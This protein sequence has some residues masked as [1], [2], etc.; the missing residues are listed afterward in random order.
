MA[1][2]A[3]LFRL[4][5][6]TG[7][8]LAGL[9]LGP[10]G[11]GI[12]TQDIVGHQLDHF[13]QI[14][15]MLIAFGIGEHVELRRLKSVARD[16]G[17]I[18]IIQ[19]VSAFLLVSVSVYAVA[20]RGESGGGLNLDHLVLALLLGAIAVA[21]AP[22]AILHLV[23]ELKAR[24]PLTSTLMAV[25]AVDD[26]IAIM[27]FGIAVSAAHQI[28][29]QTG[30][31]IFASIL[32]SSAE[33][34]LSLVMGWITGFTMDQ[35]MKK[36]H[37]G[38]ETL[39]GGL[40]ILLILGEATRMLHLSPLLAG[41]MAGFTLINRAERDVRLFRTINNFEPPIFVLFF[42]LAGVHLDISALKAGG[43]IGATYFT[44]RIIGKYGGA[45][46]GGLLS[47]ARPTVRNYLGL[48]LIPQA[49]VAIGLVFI[50]ASDPQLSPWATLITPIVLAGVVLSEL[51]GPLLARVALEKG[52]ETGQT[53]MGRTYPGQRYLF[54]LHRWLRPHH[55]FSLPPWSDTPLRPPTNP[56]GV[57][58]FSSNDY[59]PVR[60]LARIATILAHH[61]HALPLAV[62][63]LP[64]SEKNRHPEKELASYFLSEQ[65]E[66]K[67]LGYPLLTEII[68]DTPAS[69]L[70]A[71]TEY[72][73]AR[74]LV[75]GYPCGFQRT[76]RYR[77]LLDQVSK[78]VLCPVITVRLFA[79]FTGDRIL[80]PFLFFNELE[81]LMPVV[82]AMVT[83]LE[84]T[85][86]LLHLLNEDADQ[87]EVRAAGKKLEKWLAEHLVETETRFRVEPVDSRLEGILRAAKNHNL[88]IMTA[89]QRKGLSRLFLGSLADSVLRNCHK[90]IIVVSTPNKAIVIP[91]KTSVLQNDTT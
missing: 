55:Q 22:A 73:Q 91:G 12:I 1:K 69:G 6:V 40:A 47:G 86:T 20:A 63:V 4:P 53:A 64:P 60:G 14:A 35:V 83:V 41:M 46:L 72:H 76:S 36:L 65:D 27:I 52:K 87:K 13:S 80:V 67:R 10:S 90:P 50:V 68:F 56:Q 19:A 33:I 24:G 88:I 16:V 51:G 66:V 44:A 2:L 61:Y 9:L 39:T 17:F 37:E 62:R 21:T 54:F 74:A 43:L 23:R 57:V 5:S 45:W 31:S 28:V 15:L 49:G 81:Q 38:G 34:T 32:A 59:A 25:V 18:A 7:F 30:T 89:A 82:E 77:H 71:A 48:A 70:V 8:I 78:N 79:T 11:F 84:S 58:T 75:M 29:G 26:G 3:Q 42:T 85:V